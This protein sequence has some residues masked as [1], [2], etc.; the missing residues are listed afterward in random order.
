[1]EFDVRVNCNFVSESGKS[2]LDIESFKF[3]TDKEHNL[4]DNYS[5]ENDYFFI[6]DNTG[7]ANYIGHKGK[8]FVT[9]QEKSEH[10]V[11]SMM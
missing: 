5:Q 1:M 9:P 7:F 8:S 6:I 10:L 3:P 2:F 11:L 4:L